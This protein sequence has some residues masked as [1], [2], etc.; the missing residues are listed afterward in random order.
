MLSA[1]V[2]ATAASLTSLVAEQDANM[3]NVI[4]RLEEVGRV[5]TSSLQANFSDFEAWN[6]VQVC[7]CV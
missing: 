2:N 6:A 4:S 3:K 5:S 1:S 7:V